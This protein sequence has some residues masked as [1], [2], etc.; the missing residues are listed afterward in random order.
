MAAPFAFNSPPACFHTYVHLGDLGHSNDTR[1]LHELGIQ[2][3]WRYR[4]PI[5]QL[6]DGAEPEVPGHRDR[7]KETRAFYDTA[8][9]TERCVDLRDHRTES[10]LG[11]LDEAIAFIHAAVEARQHILVHCEAG[12]SR[13]ASAVLAFLVWHDHHAHGTTWRT[14]DE[15]IAE[16]LIEIRL[17]R[18]VQPNASFVQQLRLWASAMTSAPYQDAHVQINIERLL[19]DP[20]SKPAVQYCPSMLWRNSSGWQSP[21]DMYKDIF[22]T[23][24]HD[25][26]ARMDIAIIGMRNEPM[27]KLL[28]RMDSLWVTCEG[29]PKAT[30]TLSQG[31]RA[32]L[33]TNENDASDH[34]IRE[35]L[36]RSFNAAESRASIEDLCARYGGEAIVPVPQTHM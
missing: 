16:K 3:V 20:P 36:V 28:M 33:Q 22:G 21:E 29:G 19:R 34:L 2:R 9:I 18:D 14:G 15:A 35:A 4:D 30:I 12:R 1:L 23:P 31:L 17:Q 11:T 25:E 13:S 7:K 27:I 5:P 32:M 24:H 6:V 8:N 10:I 26:G